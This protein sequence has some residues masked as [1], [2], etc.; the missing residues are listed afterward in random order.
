MRVYIYACMCVYQV[1]LDRKLWYFIS[2]AKFDSVHK[3]AYLVCLL[4]LLRPGVGGDSPPLASSAS[5]QPPHGLLEA[6]PP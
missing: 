3:F 2:A 4:T 6:E 1:T 5:P